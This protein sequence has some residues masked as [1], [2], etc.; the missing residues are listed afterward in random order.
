MNALWPYLQHKLDL[1]IQSQVVESIS[2][3]T[4]LIFPR[5]LFALVDSATWFDDD[6]YSGPVLYILSKTKLT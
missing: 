4:I 3:G 5:M 6:R 2:A 1:L